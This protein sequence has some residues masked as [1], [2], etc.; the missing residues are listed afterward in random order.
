MYSAWING[1]N[2]N[3]NLKLHVELCL[4]KIYVTTNSIA[5]PVFTDANCDVFYE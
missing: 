1:Y 3:F 4:Q 5:L 2:S